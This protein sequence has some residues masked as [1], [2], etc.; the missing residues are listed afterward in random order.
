MAFYTLVYASI[1][2]DGYFQSCRE[3]RTEV[4]KLL[5]ASGNTVNVIK[6]RLSCGSIFD[7]MDYLHEDTARY[8]VRTDHINT[9]ISFYFTLI[10]SWLSEILWLG[11]SFINIVLARQSKQTD[12]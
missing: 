5:S 6:G 12:V 1:Y 11:I 8:R 4:I 7:F 3:Y 9:A 2:T 10:S